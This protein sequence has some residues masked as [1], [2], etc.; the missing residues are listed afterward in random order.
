[1]RLARAPIPYYI[2]GVDAKLQDAL[3]LLLE[4]ERAGVLA[5]EEL[6][7]EVEQEEL[8]VFLRGSRDEEARN[9]REL[10]ALIR[11]GGG[12]PSD[13]TGPFAA[14]VAA[15]P[16]VRERLN[17]MS[18]GQEW[19]ARKTE[20]ALVLAPAAGPIHDFLAAMAN[21]HRAEVEW[22]RAEVIRLM[23]A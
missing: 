21:H 15:L 20:D 18:R 2:R 16:T 10:E 1:L 19:A 7:R 5:L 13:Q 22:G 9:V 3:N 17:L 11:G 8:R 14:K 6:I 23:N 12:R 4:S